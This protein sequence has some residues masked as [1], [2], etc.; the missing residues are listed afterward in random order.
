MEDERMPSTLGMALAAFL[1]AF[2]AGLVWRTRRFSLR[3]LF[4]T[5][6]IAALVLGL[7]SYI[8]RNQ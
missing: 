7:L 1:L 8:L 6:T 2:I 3:F 4:V 5:M